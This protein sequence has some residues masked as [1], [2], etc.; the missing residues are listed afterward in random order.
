MAKLFSSLGCFDKKGK[1]G[2]ICL[3]SLGHFSWEKLIRKGL[4]PMI[5]II[6][7]SIPKVFMHDGSRGKCYKNYGRH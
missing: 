4:T 3:I 7:V 1:V 5:R 6:L 2:V